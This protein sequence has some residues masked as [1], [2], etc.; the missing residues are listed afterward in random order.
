MRFWVR[1]S[2]P[3]KADEQTEMAVLCELL[4]LG[5]FWSIPL[6]FTLKLPASNKCH[7]SLLSDGA[8]TLRDRLSFLL[9]LA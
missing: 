4:G 5:E 7:P 1:S 6:N 9:R 3:A 2:K 8:V